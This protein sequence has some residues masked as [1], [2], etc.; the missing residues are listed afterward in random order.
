MLTQ[1]MGTEPLPC[2][3]VLLPLLPLFSKKQTQA[4]VLSVNGPFTA[5]I[6]EKFC[7]RVNNRL[8]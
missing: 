3:C 5:K 4:L 1:R 2:N 6:K 7:F 8:V